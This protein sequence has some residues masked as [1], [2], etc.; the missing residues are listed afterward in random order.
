MDIFIYLD[1]TVPD[2]ERSLQASS[3]ALGCTP[4]VNLFAQHCEPIPLDHTTIEYRIVPDARRPASVE[5]WSVDRVRESLPGGGFRPW[6][7]FHRLARSHAGEAGD[8]AAGGFYGTARRAAT[9]RI[10]GTDVF[11]LP[12]D[13]GFDPSQ[14]SNGVLSI[15]ALCC[16]RDL[17]ASLPFGG[18]RPA[19]RLVEGAAVVT[20][21]A[22]LTAPTPTLRLPL[23]ERGFW[24]LISHLSPTAVTQMRN[25]FSS[26]RACDSVSPG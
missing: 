11:L 16:N 14:E 5:V 20:E 1:R 22:C 21:V 23:Q 17:P 18:G 9:G 8:S 24:R 4:I 3:L 2:L 25:D 10:R 15:D 19:L 12:H 7:P 26:V 6:V 13:P